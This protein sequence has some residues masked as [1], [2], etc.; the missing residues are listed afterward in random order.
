ME[1]AT[2]QVQFCSE[3]FVETYPLRLISGRTMSANE[4]TARHKV[5]VVTQQLVKQYL[6]GMDPVGQTIRLPLLTKLTVPITDPTFTIVGVVSDTLNQ[7]PRQAPAPQVYVPY[8]HRVGTSFLMMVRTSSEPMAIVRPVR[9][10]LAALDRQAALPPPVAVSTV[11]D[12]GIYAQPRFVLIVL[13]MFAATGLV[14]VALGV[15]GVLAYTVSQRSQEI[16]IRMALGGERSHV[17]RLV[18]RMG[19]QLTGAGVLVGLGASI[20]TNHLLAS[21]LWEISPYDP[22]T[23][24]GGV[25]IVLLIACT[26]CWVP[27]HRAMRVQPTAALRHE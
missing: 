22:A 18:F 3:E 11:L 20:V 26:A 12:N 9:A 15:Y 6:P 5:A 24:A 19:L 8:T 27:A 10:E 14:L 1:K 23:L 2:A 25:A 4:V 7:G 16:A 13:G 21:Q 17:L